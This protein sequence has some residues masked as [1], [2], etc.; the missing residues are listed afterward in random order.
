ML[1]GTLSPNI[2]DSIGWW[3]FDGVIILNRLG[4]ILHAYQMRTNIV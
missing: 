3:L 2:V 4:L 1:E